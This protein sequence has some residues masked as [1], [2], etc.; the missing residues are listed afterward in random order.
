METVVFEGS[1]DIGLGVTFQI[2]NYINGY[3]L[4]ADA[5][6]NAGINGQ[7]YDLERYV[8]SIIYNY[9]FLELSMKG[10]YLFYSNDIVE[11]KTQNIT[12]V[13]HDLEKT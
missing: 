8:Y 5:L 9:K 12:R 2:Y 4:S 6:V 7:L 10:I 1:A 13:S 3:K 11:I